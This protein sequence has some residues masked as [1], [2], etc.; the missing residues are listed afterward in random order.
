MPALTL[1]G[2]GERDRIPVL[3]LDEVAVAM[4]CRWQ[5]KLGHFPQ[6]SSQKPKTQQGPEKH[7][8]DTCHMGRL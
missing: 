2:D 1:G 6:T 8:P 5:Q 3:L 7:G 4:V